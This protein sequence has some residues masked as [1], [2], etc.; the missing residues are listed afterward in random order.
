MFKNSRIT[1]YF[2]NFQGTLAKIYY[3]YIKK[4]TMD[5][6][7]S[8]SYIVTGLNSATEENR[9]ISSEQ[10]AEYLNN[11]IRPVVMPSVVFIGIEMV[12]GFTGN[13]LVLYVFS[14]RYHVCNYKYFVL[15][16]AIIDIFTTV[17]TMPGDII[18]QLYWYVYSF[19]SICKVKSFLNVFTLTAEALYL[20]AIAVDRYR[21][22]CHPLA[23]Q[24][25]KKHTQ[26][27]C[28]TIP[29]V[30]ALVALPTPFL[31]GERTLQKTYNNRTVELTVCEKDE[32]FKTENYPLIYIS[33]VSFVI[34]VILVLMLC[35][36][37]YVLVTIVQEMRIIKTYKH[38][39]DFQE[40]Q[41]SVNTL[42]SSD[43]EE[44]DTSNDIQLQQEPK[45]LT[46]WMLN[47]KTIARRKRVRG[48][49][50]VMFCV[51]LAFIVTTIIYL[52][53]ICIIASSNDILQTLNDD[54]KAVYFFFLRLYFINHVINPFIY[55]VLDPRFKEN[56]KS[57]KQS[58]KSRI[59]T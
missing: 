23:W 13:L 42:E 4:L 18:T 55:G 21:K 27:I 31:W 35:S 49:A 53:L 15:S 19:P 54:S 57:L 48:K 52:V 10:I 38:M 30:S 51:T 8:S 39:N 56:L 14:R 1:L 2:D 34:S 5:M 29:L 12:F 17:T 47:S 43:L 45:G 9:N 25:K 32:K 41:A 36:Y 11:D 50:I 16:L 7:A 3:T 37:S 28:L 44:D 59:L 33:I 22:V 40:E 20:L 6:D 26:Y 46:P 24:I 58:I